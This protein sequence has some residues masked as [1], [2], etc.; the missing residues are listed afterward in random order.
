MAVNQTF[1][2]IKEKFRK[3]DVDE[4]IEI[5]TTVQGLTVEQYKEL[6]RMFPIKYLDKLERAMG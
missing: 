2:A 5:Y 4:K 6:L 3:A 1:E